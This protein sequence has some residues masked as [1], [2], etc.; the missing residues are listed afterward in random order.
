M[1]VHA[2]FD[3][4]SRYAFLPTPNENA[5]LIADLQQGSMAG[6]IVVG[7]RP[8]EIAASDLMKALVVSQPSDKSLSLV[9]LTA[10]S[11][12]QY[13]Y[14]LEITPDQIRLSP[15]GDTLAIYDQ[16]QGVLEVHALRR[17]EVLLRIE[18]VVV[19]GG[20]TFNS[21]GLALYW[22][23]NDTGMLNFSDLWS[24]R[25]SLRISHPG[26]EK[27]GGL[28]PLTRSVDGAL[29]FVS[30][31][32]SGTVHVIDLVSMRIHS[33]I[34]VGGRPGRPWG[35]AN[36]ALMMVP[37]PGDGSVTAISMQDLEISFKSDAVP[38]PI[39]V[40]PGWLD[41]LIAVIG[42]TG[43]IAMLDTSTGKVIETF[44]LGGT[45]RQGVVTSDSRTLA[46]P[47]AGTGGLALFD[48]KTRTLLHELKGLPPDVGELSLALS[49]N[50][51]H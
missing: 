38:D 46:V 8:G 2:A 13:H 12:D 5:I 39:A 19:S 11:L 4:G 7:H 3:D 44:R 32:D 24:R 30:D 31:A 49:N 47:L 17:R 25:Q 33:I 40:N 48:L 14:P 29:G 1:H 34:D 26:G 6:K 42:R 23:D 10:T 45:A 27:E 16:E 43:D 20:V 28:S 9:D 36:G 15:Q 35:T 50:L 22:V 18:D 37:N 51:C 21:D 41:T